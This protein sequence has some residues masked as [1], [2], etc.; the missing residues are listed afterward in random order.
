MKRILALLLLVATMILVW[1]QEAHSEIYLVAVG[2]TDYPG[3][4]ND[5]TLPAKDAEAMSKLYK[6][7][8]SAQTVLLTNSDATISNIVSQ[9]NRLYAQAKADDIVV[10][11]FSGHGTKG[12][13]CAYDGLLS[14]DK[15]RDSMARS[16]CKNKMIFADACFSGK[17]RQEGHQEHSSSLNIML[18]LS[19]RDTETSIESPSMKNGFFTSCLLRCLKGGADL[20]GDRIITA[21]EL[22]TSVSAGVITLSS[23]KQHPVMWGNFDDNM[24]VM[25]W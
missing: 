23:D 25:K 7:N 20:N 1:P 9:M 19:S 12:S 5:L 17:M 2:V 10:F 21:K 6:K 14:Y 24:P 4:Q 15:I 16:S 8:N 11:F 3:T 18:F 13:F 22:F